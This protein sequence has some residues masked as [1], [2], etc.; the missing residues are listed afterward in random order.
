[1]TSYLERFPNLYANTTWRGLTRQPVYTV[2][3]ALSALPARTVGRL[4]DADGRY[5]D[6]PPFH[7]SDAR[8]RSEDRDLHRR[9]AYVAVR[10][11]PVDCA[12]NSPEGDRL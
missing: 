12:P 3:D 9:Y 6:P 5:S 1:M 7:V 8:K 10:P 11:A 4:C 2:V